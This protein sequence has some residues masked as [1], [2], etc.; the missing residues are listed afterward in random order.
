MATPEV[1]DFSKLLAPIPGDSPS[2]TDLRAD[3]SAVSDLRTTRNARDAATAAERQQIEKGDETIVPDWRPVLDRGTKALAEKTKDLDIT[4]W[5]TEALVRLRGFAGLR[6]GFRLASELVERFWESLYPPPED[7]VAIEERFA[8]VLQLSGIEKAGT[9]I[10]PVRRIPLCD[11]SNVGRLSY[12]HYLIAKDLDQLKDADAKK[13]RIEGGAVTLE[14]IR[15]GIAE[16]PPKFYGDLME[17]L[18]QAADQFDRFC[19]S[20]S[21]KSGYDPPSG[22]L[23]KVI[24][25]YRDAV[26]LLAKDR[27]PKPQAA[28]AVAAPGTAAAG[29]GAVPGA[30]AAP[31]VDPSVIKD[32]NDAMDRLLKIAGYFRTNEPQSI[33]PY[34]L[35]QIVT[36]GKMSLPELLSELIPDEGQRKNVFKQVGIKPPEKEKSK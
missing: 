14:M 3:P 8:H 35:E 20:F 19:A 5:L 34:A 32:R 1:L 30:A 27:I 21:A 26:T 10:V 2:G 11:S 33:I 18:Q 31:P 7:G 25:D 17:D 15:T 16:T 36:W 13:K 4:A 22:D 6:D 23:K 9:L 24:E 28:A 29:G 12:A